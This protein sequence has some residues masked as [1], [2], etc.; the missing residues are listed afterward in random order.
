[1]SLKTKCIIGSSEKVEVMETLKLLTSVSRVIDLLKKS[2][3]IKGEL[4][5]HV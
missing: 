1:M 5:S 4:T 3:K 2:F